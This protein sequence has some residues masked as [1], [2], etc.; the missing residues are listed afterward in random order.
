MEAKKPQFIKMADL[1]KSGEPI[2]F[3]SPM[4]DMEIWEKWSFGSHA[5]DKLQKSS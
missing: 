5:P 3:N 4:I 2:P 1:V